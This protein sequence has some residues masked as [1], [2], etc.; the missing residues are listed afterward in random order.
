MILKR[1]KLPTRRS[2]V[3]KLDSIYAFKIKTRDSL[4]RG[5]CPF[6]ADVIFRPIEHVFHFITRAKHS[7]RWDDRNAVGSCSRCNLLYEYDQTFV[8]QVLNWYKTEVGQG[9]WDQLVLDSHKI[10][11]RS[12]SDLMELLEKID[13][14]VQLKNWGSLYPDGR[15]KIYG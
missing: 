2:L 14:Q 8:D 12:R 5:R 7:V 9:A 4:I 15:P 11:K 1:K 3:N 6:H 10:V 13:G